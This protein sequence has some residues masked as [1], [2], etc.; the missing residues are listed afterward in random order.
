MASK[1][2]M[3]AFISGLLQRGFRATRPAEGSS[4]GER[5]PAAPASQ[6]AAALAPAIDEAPAAR[7]ARPAEAGPGPTK[8]GPAGPAPAWDAQAGGERP[9]AAAA[10]EHLV[11]TMFKGRPAWVLRPPAAT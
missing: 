8:P 11:R 9:A 7:S 10:G 2:R 5:A 4:A 1:R 3:S 6:P